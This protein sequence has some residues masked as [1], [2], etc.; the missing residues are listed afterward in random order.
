[1]TTRDQKQQRPRG[2]HPRALCLPG[3]A[4]LERLK[5]MQQYSRNGIKPTGQ[6]GGTMAIAHEDLA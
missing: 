3:R 1:M 2:E 5:P 4:R 6:N